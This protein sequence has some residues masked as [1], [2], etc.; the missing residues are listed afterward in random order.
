MEKTLSKYK[1]GLLI[2]I[3]FAVA[4][5]VLVLVQAGTTK[6]DTTT[7]NAASNIADTLNNYVDSNSTIPATLAEAGVK[8]VPSTI[9][10]QKLS[11]SSYKFCVTYKGSSSGFDASGVA[12][13]LV[14]GSLS[15]DFGSATDNT[16][17]NIDSTYHKGVNCQTVQPSYI[18]PVSSEPCIGAKGTNCT[19]SGSQTTT[20]CDY[21][22]VQ[23]GGCSLHCS[24]VTS[25]VTAG[26]AP[27]VVDGTIS[28]V[29]G[30]G[31]SLVLTVADA[32]NVTYTVSVTSSTSYYDSS[33]NSLDATDIQS[34]DEVRVSYPSATNNHVVASE[35]DDLS[36]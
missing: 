25:G 3:L 10:Y 20:L 12:S 26:T 4:L 7:N 32:K 19:D 33:C 29:T 13:D 35:I 2:L 14:T 30:S 6:T 24:T 22:P 8:N 9:S 21:G 31:S 36:W 34:G 5:A 23:T 15:S 18:T 1:I 27:K 16:E 11:D 17:L 28:T